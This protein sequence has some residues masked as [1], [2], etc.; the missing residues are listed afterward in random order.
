MPEYCSLI[1][2]DATDSLIPFVPGVR[3]CCAE[4]QS[5]QRALRRGQWLFPS[6]LSLSGLQA[7]PLGPAP[8]RLH[9]KDPEGPAS[10]LSPPAPFP[11]LVTLGLPALQQLAH[12]WTP[13][14]QPPAVRLMP[15]GAQSKPAGMGSLSPH[16]EEPMPLAF[17]LCPREPLPF[18]CFASLTESL[19]S[20]LRSW[21]SRW[22]A[23]AISTTF[24]CRRWMEQSRSYRCRMLPYWS[25]GVEVD[26]AQLL[27]GSRHP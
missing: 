3:W 5:V 12:I 4:T 22:A 26:C 10:A 13:A 25:P 7:W 20:R 2:T 24:W 11:E 27:L 18:T 1:L 19:V 21:G 6:S 15:A 14:T 17:K 23:G 9:S 8:L 16:G